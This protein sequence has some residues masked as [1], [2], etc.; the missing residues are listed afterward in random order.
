ME[1]MSHESWL[2][3]RQKGIGAS[4]ASAVIGRNPYKTNVELWEEKTGKREP[5]DISHKPYVQYGTEA[6][7]PLR[8]LFALDYPQYEVEYQNYD[9]FRHSEHP[10]IFATLDGRLTEKDTGRCGVL[11][12]KTTEI[13][14]SMQ[15]ESWRDKMPENYF[16]QIIHQLLATGWDFAILKAQLKTSYQGDIRLNVRHYLIERSEVIEDLEYLLEKELAFWKMVELRKRPPLILP[17]I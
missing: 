8:D 6:E 12:I 7:A 10:F 4:D 11:E 16:C 1:T 14:R 3:A 17:N 13:L 5:E 2:Q 15:Y 9:M